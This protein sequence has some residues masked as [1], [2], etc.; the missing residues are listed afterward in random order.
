LDLDRERTGGGWGRI[1][2]ALNQLIENGINRNAL[3]TVDG[4]TLS[5]EGLAQ[6]STWDNSDHVAMQK[7]INKLETYHVYFSAP[8]DIDF[9]M[10]ES[11]SSVYKNTLDNGEGPIYMK[12]VDGKNVQ[13]SVRSVEDEATP[14]NEYFEYLKKAIHITLK[15]D[16][17]DGI[18]YSPSQHKLMP[19]YNYFFLNRGKPSTHIAAMSS[20]NEDILKEQA[21]DVLKRLMNAAKTTLEGESHE[22]NPS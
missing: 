12:S 21:P 6:M 1:K 7:W 17:A 18:T 4:T 3:L 22:D 9:M 15:T 19:W 16:T 14:P 10:L 11:Y 8:L 20:I 5:A 2:Y 13:V